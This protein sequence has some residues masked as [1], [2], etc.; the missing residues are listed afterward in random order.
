MDA[1]LARQFRDRWQ[2][3]AEVE[4]TE[5]RRA[6][7]EG[8]W[9]QLNAIMKMALDLGLDLTAQSEDDHVVWERWARLKEGLP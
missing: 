1:E 5:R 4:A 6:T 8:R 2:A 9:R 3:V 7:V